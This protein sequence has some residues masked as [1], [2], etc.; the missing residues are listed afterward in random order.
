MP[1]SPLNRILQVINYLVGALALTAVSAV[2]WYAWRPLPKTSGGV[3]APVLARVSIARDKLGVPHIRASNEEDA[4]FAQGYATAQ[5]RLFQMEGLRR[6]SSGTLAEIVGPAALESD[7]DARRLR[8]RRL[9]EAA[10]LTLLPEDRAGL[11]AYARGVNHFISTHRSGLPVEFTL[12]RFEPRPWSAVD[13]LLIGLHMFRTLT[14]T[15]KDEIA[16]RNLLAGGNREKV[17]F[18][19]PVRG[20]GD[21]QPGSNAWAIA[22]AR[23]ASG[24]PL[25]SSDMHLEWSLP[26][27]WY[28]THLQGGSLDVSGVAL[29]GVPGVIVGHNRRIAWGITNLQADVQDLYQEKFDDRTGRYEFRGHIE[30][31]RLE[32]EV[33]EIKGAQRVELPLW[34]T[35][36]GPIFIAESQDRLALRWVAA[37]PGALQVPV[38]AINRAGNWDEFKRAIARF[39]GPGSNFVYAD[40]DGNIGYHAAGMLPVRRKHRGDL[41]VEGW[42]GE[43]E[44]DGFIPFEELPQAF[45]PPSGMIVSANEN[46]F[47]PDFAYNING[48]FAP[49]HRHRQIGHLLAARKEWKAVDLLAVQTDVYSSFSKALAVQ[50]VAACDRRKVTNPAL[51]EPVRLLREWNGQMHPDLAA[52]FVAA[53]AY[54]HLRK[55][56]GESASPGKGPLYEFNLAPVAIE[57]LLREKPPGWFRDYDETL[58]RVLADAVDECV[59]IQGKDPGRWRYGLYL[60][61]SIVNPVVHQVP[62]IG[63]Y[64]DLRDVQLGGS[65]TA[66]KQTT[67]RLGPS[68][69]M[70]ADLSDWD[71]SLLNLPIGQS[72]QV[73]SSHYRDQ[74]QSYLSGRSFSMQFNKVEAGDVLE[75]RPSR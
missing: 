9:A 70:N 53:L 41:P 30:Q 19:Y 56:A 22:G 59:R 25:L 73:L 47:P 45:N 23:T 38:L 74:W 64:F 11:A 26:G 46:P 4:I 40:V 49:N 15:W 1:H 68:M 6:L 5:D 42:S 17:E 51:S 33:I 12:M 13:S 39:H 57:R 3:D 65:T 37:E 52:P 71:R 34:V 28:M 69:R 61:I 7:R 27:V 31:A 66:V 58:V 72:G 36:H 20:G 18:L 43:Y 16:K 14:S 62:W 24:K 48:N 10:Y 8:L 35:R 63:P 55:A 75:L 67:W 54:Q 50:L 21:A 29:P 60:R 44:W 2:A 32:R